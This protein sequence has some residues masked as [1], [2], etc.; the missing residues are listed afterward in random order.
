[1]RQAGEAKSGSL[2]SWDGKTLHL[3]GIKEGGP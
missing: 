1:M 3:M 2:W